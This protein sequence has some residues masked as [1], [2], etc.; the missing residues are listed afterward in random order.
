[1]IFQIL[2]CAVFV[3]LAAGI[4]VRDPPLKPS[5]YKYSYDV[6][7][8]ATGDSKTQQ[9]EKYGDLVKGFYTVVDPDGTKRTVLYSADPVKGFNA[10]V[11]TEPAE[12]VGY[13]YHI[14]KP[15][16]DSMY[17]EYR[18]NQYV[19]QTFTA[20]AIS[21]Q[22]AQTQRVNSDSY[23]YPYHYYTKNDDSFDDRHLFATAQE[24]SPMRSEGPFFSINSHLFQPVQ[25]YSYN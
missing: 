8:P 1:M 14:S 18:Q 6:R 11:R 13:P 17:G 19:P 23:A 15:S 22:K 3:P 20:P 24:L 16:T 5:E 25:K 9:E 10:V 7:D 4:I 12:S 21:Y 2:T